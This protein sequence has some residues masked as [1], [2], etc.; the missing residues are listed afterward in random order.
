MAIISLCRTPPS[1]S[2]LR[3]SSARLSARGGDSPLINPRSSMRHFIRVSIPMSP[4][5]S[6]RVRA[7]RAPR[8][9]A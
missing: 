3:T 8:I 2:I 4:R 1:A 5:P 6:P 7:S 9:F